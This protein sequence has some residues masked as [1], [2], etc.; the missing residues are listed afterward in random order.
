MQ[1]TTR[2]D[3][4]GTSEGGVVLKR[5][6]SITSVLV[7]AAASVSLSATAS[8][9]KSTGKSIT[10][11]LVEKSVGFNYID[12]PPRQGFKSPPLIGDQFAFSADLLTR[13]G[14]HAGTF[15]ATCMVARGGVHETDV[16]YGIYS[17]KGGD[18]TGIARGTDSNT[19]HIAIV[20]GTGAYERVTGSSTEVSRG[21]NSPLTD[22]TIDLV[23]P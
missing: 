12:N 15:G 19:T 20:G 23:Y 11:H 21:N 16:S 8:S 17:L 1:I 14:Q 3:G 5:L 9:S 13:S 7:I 2:G 22:V 6:V 10:L 18:I 4:A